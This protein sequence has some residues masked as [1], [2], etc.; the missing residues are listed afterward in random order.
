MPSTRGSGGSNPLHCSMLTPRE[1]CPLPEAQE[2]RTPTLQHVNSKGKM[3]S[4]RGSGG[5]NPQHCIMQDSE[6]NTLLTELFWPL[7]STFEFREGGV[8]FSDHSKQTIPHVT[9]LQCWWGSKDLSTSDPDR[10]NSRVVRNTVA[11][12]NRVHGL[13]FLVTSC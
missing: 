12:T 1:K 9:T 8:K 7:S 10:G 13:V 5:S 6:P 3:P 11:T 2:G 4:T